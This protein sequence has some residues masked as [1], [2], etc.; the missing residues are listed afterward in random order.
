MLHTKKMRKRIPDDVRKL[1]DALSEELGDVLLRA[2]FRVSDELR[3][4]PSQLRWLASGQPFRQ[5]FAIPKEK[6]PK[7]WDRYR[8]YCERL[9][10][11]L[12]KGKLPPRKLKA[13]IDRAV[14]AANAVGTGRKLSKASY[15]KM[16][17][18][19]PAPVLASEFDEEPNSL[20]THRKKYSRRGRQ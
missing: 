1:I 16:Q 9:E 17:S 20:E 15:Q 10:A 6:E 13:S 7:H 14:V 19:Y 5:A 11:D 18:T 2:K 12:K 4:L 3:N 8:V